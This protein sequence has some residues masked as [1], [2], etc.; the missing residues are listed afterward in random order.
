MCGIYA[1]TGSSNAA[2]EV[3][4]GLKKLEYRGYDSWGITIPL[5]GKLMLERHTGKIGDSLT[6]LPPSS[7]GLG[8]TRWATHGGVT[9]A[10]AHPHLDCSQTFALVHNGIVENYREL[11]SS[12]K[13]KHHFHSQ[14]DT[15][16]LVHLVEEYSQHFLFAQAVATAFRQ[17]K[18][19]NACIF[20]SSKNDQFVAVKNGSP[21]II[22]LSEKGNLIASDSASLS[23]HTSKVIYLE[24]HE[25]AVITKDQVDLFDL[26]LHP[27]KLKKSHL[28]FDHQSSS[29]GAHRYF[30]I[31]EIEEQPTV[32]SR[33]LNNYSAQITPFAHKLK[34]YQL[35]TFF[36]C[37][38]AAYAALLGKYYFAGAGF[39]SDVI[40]GSEANHFLSLIDKHTLPIFLSQSGETI[41]IIEPLKHVQGLGLKAAALV[42]AEGSTLDRLADFKL[43]L[44][45]GPEVSVIA[46]KS[47]T[48]KIASLYLTSQVLAGKSTSAKLHLKQA[49]SSSQQL[50]L[51]SYFNH[52][53]K[54]LIDRLAKHDHLYTL[55]R[56]YA[57]PIALE[58][59]LKIKEISYIHAEGFATG[60]LKHGFL[61]LI[62][63]GTPCI[64]FAPSDQTLADTLS[65][66]AQVKARGGYI[67]GV[68]PQNHQVFDYHLPIAAAGP[69][70]TI[71]EAI[72]AQLL[73]YHLALNKGLDPDKP[74]NLAKS[75]TVK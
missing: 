7:T 63:P 21:L 17:A 26:N 45:A 33:F 12:L 43:N 62:E 35:F 53:L 9:V 8:H 39:N 48:A 50:F 40:V 38:T 71:P 27:K 28:N 54:P 70:S 25:L 69:L 72:I 20:Y 52:H 4:T 16:V 61:A 67:V 32:L 44:N 14:T 15:E 1:I 74:R 37:G 65:N 29:K 22:G 23:S 41:D 49:I 42:N 18:G 3:L 11:K 56:G 13:S 47:F 58:A 34:P 31:K 59:A 46:T 66:A 30:A 60:E 2:Q 36:G 55:G 24:D 5:A 6:A 57:Y 51:P 64:F 19:L 68:A 75:V 10:N 73:G